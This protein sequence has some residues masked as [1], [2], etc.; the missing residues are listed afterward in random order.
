M[1]FNGAFDRYLDLQV[2]EYFGDED[3]AQEA[4]ELFEAFTFGGLRYLLTGTY[5][6]DNLEGGRLFLCTHWG[7][8]EQDWG[9]TDSLTEAGYD[10]SFAYADADSLTARCYEVADAAL[11]S[12]EAA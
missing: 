10:F 12:W 7:L 8:I 11:K 4:F 9:I 6:G 5:E 2:D 3:E 1:D